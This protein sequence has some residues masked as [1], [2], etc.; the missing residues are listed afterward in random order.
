MLPRLFGAVSHGTLDA[1]AAVLYLLIEAASCWAPCALKFL[2][3]FVRRPDREDL[4]VEC[5]LSS[6]M[7]IDVC[8]IA[9]FGLN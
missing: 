5:V 4:S 1:A 8:C 6:V 3:F 9:C 2:L 7:F